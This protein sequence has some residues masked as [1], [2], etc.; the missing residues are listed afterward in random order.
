VQ[1]S[2][3]FGVIST[4][5]KKLEGYP[6]GAVVGFGLDDNGRPLFAFST[7]SSHTTDLA[8]GEQYTLIGHAFHEASS[9]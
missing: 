3:G 5:S 6:N 8:N 9:H 4:N 7:M 1:Y 2:T